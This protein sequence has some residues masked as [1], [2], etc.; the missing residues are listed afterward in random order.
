MEIT[1]FTNS[2]V[3]FFRPRKRTFYFFKWDNPTRKWFREGGDYPN[4]TI[5]KATNHVMS[6]AK[7]VLAHTR[8]RIL[9]INIR[10]DG[11]FLKSENKIIPILKS[12]TN[13]P[14]SLILQEYQAIQ[15]EET[16][17][18]ENQL[19]NIRIPVETPPQ[20]PQENTQKIPT[21]IAWLIAED[22][23]KNNE[24]CAITMN[25]VSPL[26]AAVTSCF[27]AFERDALEEWLL[28]KNTC[29]VCRKRCSSTRAYDEPPI[30]ILN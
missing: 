9:E 25:V 27:H 2:T 23:C 6:T 12:R 14:A 10:A 29:P 28:I 8:N 13:I 15:L 20:I 11:T 5:H 21:R 1:A 24:I 26:T 17:L 19:W 30:E 4:L 16:Y 7:L 22:A 3:A 18:T